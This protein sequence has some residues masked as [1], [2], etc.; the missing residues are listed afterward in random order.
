MCLFYMHAFKYFKISKCICVNIKQNYLHDHKPHFS[1]GLIF[2]YIIYSKTLPCKQTYFW[3]GVGHKK[4]K[5]EN[6]NFYT[7]WKLHSSFYIET[8]LC[9]PYTEALLYHL[10]GSQAEKHENRAVITPPRKK[11]L[12]VIWNRALDSFPSLA[13]R[14]YCP[15]DWWVTTR[16]CESWKQDAQ[17][18]A[19]SACVATR[20]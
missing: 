17:Q 6:W 14:L 10:L 12:V 8:S 7:E 2:I 15:E 11:R 4:P 13:W 18:S 3:W 16:A 1:H 9:I 5:K 20:P 19:D